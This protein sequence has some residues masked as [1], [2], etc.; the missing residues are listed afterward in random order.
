[1]ITPAFERRN[2]YLIR[3]IDS[4]M[5]TNNKNGKHE[6]TL[7]GDK[8]QVVN[9]LA[10]YLREKGYDVKDMSTFTDET[11]WKISLLVKW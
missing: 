9:G 6:L 11:G 5:H 1:M 2:Y 8:D 10:E 4:M 7:E 3:M